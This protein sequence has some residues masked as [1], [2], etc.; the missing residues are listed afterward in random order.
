[1]SKLERFGDNIPKL[2][3]RLPGV[4]NKSTIE[5]EKILEK[6]LSENDKVYKLIDYVMEGMETGKLRYS[7]AIKAFATF[8]PFLFRTLSER[9]TEDV[10]ER[11]TSKE[12]AEIEINEILETIN[13]LRVV[14]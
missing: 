9:S 7:E 3:G 5:R 2:T 11:I 10:L 14:K 13:H 6:R 1:M 8:A 4:K 12:Q